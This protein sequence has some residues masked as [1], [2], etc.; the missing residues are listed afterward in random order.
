MKIGVD[1]FLKDLFG[2]LMF[3][4]VLKQSIESSS[5]KMKDI[6]QRDIYIST[7]IILYLEY[8]LKNSTHCRHL[9]L[10]VKRHPTTAFCSNQ[11]Q[12]QSSVSEDN[13]MKI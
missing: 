2:T 5:S 8:L 13:S 10:Y 6:I 7:R 4:E 1:V 11:Q 12:Q 3:P 9:Y